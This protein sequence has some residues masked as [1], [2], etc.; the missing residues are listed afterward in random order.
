M[1]RHSALDSFLLTSALLI[2]GAFVKEINAK[3]LGKAIDTI[4]GGTAAVE[5]GVITNLLWLYILE[6]SIKNDLKKSNF[7]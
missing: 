3:E 6:K 2:T 5:S 4:A 7:F 1:M